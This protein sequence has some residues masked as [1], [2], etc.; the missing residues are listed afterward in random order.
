M[1][2]IWITILLLLS[3]FV[4]G[5]GDENSSTAVETS[6]LW[7]ITPEERSIIQGDRARY[8]IGISSIS[9]I[10]I[11]KSLTLTL[12]DLPEGVTASFFPNP[13]LLPASSLLTLST[14]DDTPSGEYTLTIGHNLSENTLQTSLHVTPFKWGQVTASGKGPAGVQGH[15][16][17]YDSGADQLIV[18]G[19]ETNGGTLADLWVLDHVIS[20]EETPSW[21][22]IAVS[23]N[24]PAA[25]S[26]HRAV[27]NQGNSRMIILG[28]IDPDG[29]MVGEDDS[30]WILTNA[31]G[32]DGGDPAWEDWVDEGERPQHR[33]GFSMVYDNDNDTQNNRVIIYGGAS[34]SGGVTTLS[35]DVWVLKN[36]DGSGVEPPTWEKITPDTGSIP[37]KRT[38]HTAVYD[39]GTNTMIIMGGRTAKGVYSD[40]WILSNANGL[41][42]TPSI[43]TPLDVTGGP[44]PAREGHSAVY[45][46]STNRMTIFGGLDS[47]GE[48]LD[49]IWVLD[50]A[51]GTGDSSS[52]YQKVTYHTSAVSYPEA[53][54]LHTAAGASETNQLIVFGGLSEGSYLNDVWILQHAN[55]E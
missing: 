4:T 32:G 19:G 48:P 3:F 46:P 41:G 34:V 6:F 28:G 35:N 10:P 23:G 20:T 37:A 5:C 55:G 27:Y 8:T 52:W 49:D 44:V 17:V 26:G 2:L 11:P 9:G 21:R 13:I 18:F 15:S 42:E 29:D 43:W 45:D 25:R 30:L 50:N 31:S 36:A 12:D 14:E 7:T 22:K 54:G 1:N 16:S 38:G 51:N 33:I 24:T 39:A 47:D 53:R 40:V